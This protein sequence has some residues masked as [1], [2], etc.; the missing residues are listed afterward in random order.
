MRSSPTDRADSTSEAVNGRQPRSDGPPSDANEAVRQRAGRDNEHTALNGCSSPNGASAPGVLGTSLTGNGVQ[1]VTNESYGV[2]GT[3]TATL[4]E[5]GPPSAAVC[6]EDNSTGG[7]VSN[8]GVGVLGF[9]PTGIGVHAR[10]AIGR[11]L[12]VDGPSSFDGAMTATSIEASGD[13]SVGSL[14]ASELTAIGAITAGSVSASSEGSGTGVTGASV[15]GVGVLAESAEGTA[16]SVRGKVELTRSGLVPIPL[17]TKEATV[18]LV[19]VTQ[20]SLVFATV[21]GPSGDV[22]VANA[23]LARDSFT[24]NLTATA[25]HTLLVAWI[26]IN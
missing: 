6:G 5:D 16:L 21:Q 7:T 24:I 13:V 22:A 14:S 15:Q 9:S 20:T 10:T 4:T 18:N 26:V 8:P 3:T 2:Y 1:G 11:A 23:V 25:P 17:G 19:G 12:S